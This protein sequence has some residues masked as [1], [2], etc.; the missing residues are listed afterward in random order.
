M[1]LKQL[2]LKATDELKT[3]GCATP[4]LDAEVLLMHVSG[5]S[6]SR[7]ITCSDNKLPPEQIL[8]YHKLIERRQQREPVAYIIGEK[9]FWSLP[10]FV[11]SDVLIP[12]P[13]TEHLVEATLANFTNK[14]EKFNF[15]D[16]GTGSGCIAISLACEYPHAHITATD[17]SSNALKVARANARRHGVID[18]IDFRQGD[19][20]TVMEDECFDA[21]L[22]N[23]P[24]ISID[25]Y[26]K[27]ET[28]LYFE[29]RQAL[30]DE[31]DGLKYL[32]TLLDQAPIWL[33][34]EGILIMESGVSGLP[35][36]GIKWP[37]VEKIKDLAGLL[38]GAVFHLG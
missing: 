13:E 36:A 24:Y 35:K 25:E 5:L 33:G 14:D 21:I 16:L 32:N 23:P 9:E 22:T 28:E 2:L 26:L 12:R 8:R 11:N 3:A 1:T 4:R 34:P 29:P 17:I 37:T 31:E 6:Q 19:M 27:L 38:R 7:L 30:T 15:C 10:F 20:L 18:R